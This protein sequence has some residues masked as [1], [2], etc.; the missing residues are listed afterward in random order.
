M[1]Y[2][3]DDTDFKEAEDYLQ[4]TQNQVLKANNNKK[5]TTKLR[6]L[7]IEV[8]MKP[9]LR[10]LLPYKPQRKYGRLSNKNTKVLTELKRFI[11]NLCEVNL[12]HCK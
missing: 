5:K 12:N 6:P 4:K 10:S 8:L 3:Y 7:F 1:E 2:G 11:F 9:H